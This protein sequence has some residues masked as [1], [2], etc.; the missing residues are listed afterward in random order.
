[1]E[2][3]VRFRLMT[4]RLS[5]MLLAVMALGAAAWERDIAIGLM[6]GG[7][8]GVIAFWI[9]ARRVEKFAGASAAEIQSA[10]IKG[11]LLRMGVY[12]LALWR[13]Y[14][15]DPQSKLPLF[16]AVCG[17][18]VPRVVMYFLAFTSLDLKQKQP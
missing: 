13:A 10:A 1:M 4:V 7:L 12:G 17:I 11:M 5:L 2:T 9:L 18:L 8:S 6:M 15:L 16:A 3:L 14:D